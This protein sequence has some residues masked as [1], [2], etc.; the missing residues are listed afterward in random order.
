MQVV[1]RGGGKA[2]ANAFAEQLRASPGAVFP[3]ATFK[4]VHLEHITR[5]FLVSCRSD[6]PLGG[7]SYPWQQGIPHLGTRRLSPIQQQGVL[8]LL[9]L[10]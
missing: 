5:P 6:A 8:P 10:M 2:A 1:F 9:G 7:E 3:K 4:D